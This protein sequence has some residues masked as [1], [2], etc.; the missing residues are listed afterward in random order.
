MQKTQRLENGEEIRDN[1]IIIGITK[2]DTINPIIS[3][4]EDIQYISKI[5]D[6]DILEIYVK[7]KNTAK[8]IGGKYY[9]FDEN[10]YLIT[11][12]WIDQK[13]YAKA[14]GALAQ[15]E[16]VYISGKVYYFKPDTTVA[17]NSAEAGGLK[18]KSDGSVISGEEFEGKFYVNG[19]PHTG[20]YNGKYYTDGYIKR[21]TWAGDYYIGSNGMP[22][23][24]QWVNG[25]N[26]KKYYVGADGR[27]LRSTTQTVSGKQYEFDA[28]G[29]ATELTTWRAPEEIGVDGGAGSGNEITAVGVSLKL[30]SAYSKTVN[31][32]K[33]SY[34]TVNGVVATNND[35]SDIANKLNG[36]ISE[37]ED[38]VL[39]EL[40][41][42]ARST[43]KPQ[44]IKLTKYV[45]SNCTRK[46]ATVKATFSVKKSNGK[47]LS[48]KNATISIDIDANMYTLKMPSVKLD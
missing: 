40:E 13:Y 32:V 23:T 8:E 6:K 39:E 17:R 21:N 10:G 42:I 19:K 31:G 35:Y 25:N 37:A 1:N 22:L 41:D 3:K 29:V 12:K 7:V 18:L 27:Y 43:P 26:G 9:N 45:V 30:S 46:K 28:S 16:C 33:I 2:F 34:V 38:E 47:M 24:N 5:T 4:N 14:D 48:N 15:N 11:N 36:I 44:E 20:E